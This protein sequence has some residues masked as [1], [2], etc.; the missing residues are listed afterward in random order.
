MFAS[1]NQVKEQIDFTIISEINLGLGRMVRFLEKLGNPQDQLKII[2]IGGTNGKGST[3]RYLE[4]MLV[5]TGCTTGVFH[6]PAYRYINDQIAVN[7]AGITD[8]EIVN[9][10]EVFNLNGL[11][12]AGLTEFE[13]QTAMAFYYFAVVK[14]VDFALIEVGLGGREDS[15]NVLT[16]ILSIITNVG[17]DHVRFLGGS[18]AEI[19]YHKAGIIKKEIPVICGEQEED[20]KEVIHTEAEKNSAPFYTFADD[21]FVSMKEEHIFGE[22][23]TFSTA[24]LRMEALE[25]SMQGEH[26]V[27]NA[28]I[29][30]MAY[31]NLVERQYIHMS[32]TNLR[33]GL[34]KAEH[35]GRFE[36]ICHHPLTIMDGA[37][38]EE[39]MDALVHSIKRKYSNKKITV[40]F[41][42][43]KDKPIESMIRKLEEVAFE[44]VFTSFHY[45]RAAAAKDLYA[46]SRHTSK[47]YEEN[48]KRA[49][50]TAVQRK[51]DDG[52]L[53]VTG[54]LYFI[55]ESRTFFI[56]SLV[57]E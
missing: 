33:A 56:D 26:Q 39:A 38:N 27:R 36:L 47:T 1:F 7:G 21:F 17:Y 20:A 57:K 3:L 19:A 4:S 30:V 55:T 28:S 35:P 8:D 22:L 48:W 43:L 16:P 10:I 2:H 32:E 44:I 51:N 12:E 49:L 34:K 9:I 15:T 23:F 45:P 31:L 54:S 24:G 11:A 46:L 13:L 25:I 41:S 29:A 52:L 53:L 6:S 40:V 14:K 50:E 37:H 18:I 5:E 42:A